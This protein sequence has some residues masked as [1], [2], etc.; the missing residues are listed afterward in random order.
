MNY[1]SPDEPAYILND[2]Q[3]NYFT[4]YIKIYRSLQN[5]WLWDDPNRLQWWLIILMKVNHK[6]GKTL[7]RGTL[8]NVA[9]GES[10]N[11]L[12]TWSKL[13]RCNMQVTRTFLDL[14][15]KDNMVKIKNEKK[16]TRLSVCKYD[17]YNA[18]QHTDNMQVTRSQHAGNIQL[19]TNKN[20]NNDNN[21]KNNTLM[22]VGKF[23]NGELKSEYLKITETLKDK[24][25]K[26]VFETLKKF[27]EIH[28]PYFPEPYME[29]WN[30]VAKKYGLPL[31]DHVTSEREQKIKTR[32]K[33]HSFDFF[34]ILESIRRNKNYH[35]DNNSGWKIDF[36]YII[37]SEGNYIKIIEKLSV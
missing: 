11:S 35:G 27:I 8:F 1:K 3:E 29:V 36:D 10:L 6:P 5:H 7:I 37:K 20:G 2:E 24:D 32:S 4:G 19:T 25:A 17:S 21:E 14:L 16:T 22:R 33:E 30:I 23:L 18:S 13:F 9:R 28:K 26:H 12:I 15:Q 34:K 31:A